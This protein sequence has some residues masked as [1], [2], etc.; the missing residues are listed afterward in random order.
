MRTDGGGKIVSA[1]RSNETTIGDSDG[2]PLTVD[3]ESIPWL[4]SAF[5]QD[6]T[7]E[8]YG[9]NRVLVAYEEYE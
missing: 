4:G 9:T 1:D 7:V 5:G 8:S 6:Y 2:D 3:T